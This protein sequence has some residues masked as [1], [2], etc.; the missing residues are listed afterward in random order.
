MDKNNLVHTIIKSGLGAIP[1]GGQAAIELF[2]YIVTPP[3]LKRRNDW[4]ENVGRRLAALEAEKILDIDQLCEN[5]VFINTLLHASHIA[6]RTNQQERL[7]ALENAVVN[8]ALPDAPDEIFQQI[9]LNLVETLTT[10]HVAILGRFEGIIFGPT[11]PKEIL[12]KE[13]PE[14]ERNGDLYM[15]IWHD[16]ITKKL[17]TDRAD[18]RLGY[19]ISRTKLGHGFID[20]ISKKNL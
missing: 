19:S 12:K 5:N 13:F 14:M 3:I 8:S 18:N 7:R 20:F 16:L 4:E 2:E 17:I 10:L 11:A 9:H 1:F 6:I 15:H